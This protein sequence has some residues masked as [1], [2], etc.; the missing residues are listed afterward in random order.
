M[1]RILLATAVL[2]AFASVSM[3]QQVI[4]SGDA[5]QAAIIGASFEQGRLFAQDQRLARE[6]AA[7]YEQQTF[8]QAF[9]AQQAAN[10]AQRAAGAA[11]WANMSEAARQRSIQ[12]TIHAKAKH[13]RRAE[14]IKKVQD[15]RKSSTKSQ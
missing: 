1:K 9:I 4:I 11:A 3:A 8:Q 10:E 15:K 6:R 13:A 2:T 7:I 5:A 14:T 12:A